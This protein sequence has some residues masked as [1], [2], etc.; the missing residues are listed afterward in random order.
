MQSDADNTTSWTSSLSLAFRDTVPEALFR[1]SGAAGAADEDENAGSIKANMSTTTEDAEVS[2]LYFT[3]IGSATAGTEYVWGWFDSSDAAAYFGVMT[4]NL[5]PA[6]VA[7]YEKIKFDFNTGNDGE[8]A[9]SIPDSGYLTLPVDTVD[10]LAGTGSSK[11][12]TPVTDDA[13]NFAANFTGANLYG[14]TFIANA[15]GTTQLPAITAGMNF[16]IITLGAV[17][18]VVEPNA[19]DNF[20]ADGVQLDDADSL[21]NLSTAGD[22]A[23]FQYYSAAGWVASTN[24]WTDED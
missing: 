11:S 5:T 1:D 24:G 12:L 23:V 15:A 2:D 16:T 13:D 21:T 19:S 3:V 9:I 14:G 4:D 17:A 18:V 20:L 22:I 7:G 8:V 10:Y 6:D